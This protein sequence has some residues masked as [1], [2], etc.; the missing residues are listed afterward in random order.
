MNM[1][2]PLPALC[3]T[4]ESSPS[5]SQSQTVTPT[6]GIPKPGQPGVGGKGSAGTV[7]QREAYCEIC[8]REFCNKYFLKTHKANIHGIIDPNDPKYAGQLKQS[9]INQQKAQLSS[10]KQEMESNSSKSTQAKASLDGNNTSSSDMEDY[11]D[12]CQK[13]FCNKYYLKKHKLDTHNIR[14]DGTEVKPQVST[15]QERSS[16]F[17]LPTSGSMPHLPMMMP[18]LG[19]PGTTM[20]NMLF[21]NP[22]VPSMAAMSMVPP[23][24]QPQFFM[25]GGIPGLPPMSMNTSPIQDMKEFKMARL[26]PTDKKDS[27]SEEGGS[28]GEPDFCNICKWVD[29]LR[30]KFLIHLIRDSI[31]L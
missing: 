8:Q 22:F 12:I 29:D 9:Q 24:M 30:I 19:G 4:T 1:I 15:S 16:S 2:P 14:P 6:T 20:S 23:M 28:T 21:V 5:V 13:H 11:C 17:P 31:R 25:P 26:T 10:Y 18:G 3:K 27:K 7:F